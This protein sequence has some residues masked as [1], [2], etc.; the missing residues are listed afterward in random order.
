MRNQV[1][2]VLA[3]SMITFAADSAT[4][5]P[6][7]RSPTTT[8][9][10]G[11]LRSKDP[12]AFLTVRADFDGDGIQDVAQL[13]VNT[14]GTKYSLFVFSS[15]LRKWL[16]TGLADGPIKQLPNFGIEK[17]VPGSYETACGKGYGDYTCAHGE[18]KTLKLLF[19]AIDYFYYESS[20]SVIF[21]GGKTGRFRSV[22]MS[23]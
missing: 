15:K 4:P 7:W 9:T 8:E 23:D 1:F 18:P 16:Q 13:L 17:V 20:D 5:P 2:F 19:P 6:V 14:D 12:R 22:L 10:Q 3:A 11:E 21:W